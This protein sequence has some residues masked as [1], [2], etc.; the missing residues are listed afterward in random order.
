ME[1]KLR[2]VLKN[3]EYIEF[4]YLFGSQATGD[5]NSESD[6]DVAVYVDEKRKEDFFDIR[7]ELIEDITRATKKEADVTILNTAKPFLAFVVIQEGKLLVNKNPG[8]EVD[9]DLKTFNEY[10]DYKIFMKTHYGEN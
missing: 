1:E 3:K 10:Q 2:K 8:K 7:L 9:Y 5:T 6:V 4:A